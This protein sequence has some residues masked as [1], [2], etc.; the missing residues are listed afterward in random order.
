MNKDWYKTAYHR[1][2]V[3]MHITADS[4]DFLTCFD[5]DNYVEM[6]KLSRAQSAVVYAHSHVGMTYFPTKFGYMHPNLHGRDIFSEI[7][8]GCHREGINVVAYFSLIFDTWAYDNHPHWRMRHA[9]GDDWSGRDRF[10]VCCPNSSGYRAYLKKVITELC[11]GYDFEGIRFDMTFWPGFCYCDNC[12]R[13]FRE[14]YGAELPVT[15]NW[16][17]KTWVAYQRS[18]ERWLCE[19]AHEITSLIRII[20]PGITVEHQSSVF[21]QHYGFGVSAELSDENDFLQGDFYGG[22]IQG[23]CAC[24]IFYNLS[25]N[26][27]CGFETS[28][29][30]TL[31]DHT[32]VKSPELLELKAEMAIANS[33]A[34]IFI[35]AIDPIGTLDPYVYQTMSRVF[36]KTSRFEPFVGGELV[37]DVALYL[38]TESKFS[39]SENGRHVDSAAFVSEHL[40]ST[41]NAARALIRNHIPFGIITRKNLP[42]L[43]KFKMLLLCDV[44]MMSEEEISAIR[45][46]VRAGGKLYASKYSSLT[47]SDGTRL[48]NFGLAD[49][50]GADYT[51]ITE[52]NVTYLVPEDTEFFPA[53]INDT[54]PLY[55]DGSQIEITARDGAI[56]AARLC[57]PYFEPQ[58]RRPFS[59]IHSNPPGPVEESAAM[60]VNCFGAGECVYCA[61]ELENNI[62]HGNIFAGIVKSLLGE[63]IS[64]EGDAPRQVEV[65]IF[66]HGAR[67]Q[68]NFLTF[69]EELPNL[70]IPAFNVVIKTSRRSVEAVRLLP[71]GYILDFTDNGSQVTFT[72]PDFDNFCICSVEFKHHQ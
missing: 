34:F 71:D 7:C 47:L 43:K 6:L 11:D 8:D 42:E 65:T 33:C 36:D 30:V 2:V 28:S 37:Q 9:N 44:L 1:N 40:D 19:F 52:D 46:Y 35:D 18:R 57:K 16:T 31:A 14:E 17:D 38:S 4:D 68:A 3:D 59:S 50:F 15:M 53:H 48:S 5:T 63:K 24:K 72:V 66:D 56:T 23:S 61:A 49:V 21:N 51:G 58:K 54:H 27:P 62:S 13:R 55:I 70:P 26:L 20:K 29:N 39:F 60:T 69:Q 41:W 64:F 25:P 67:L 32:T 22:Y 45:E 12:R 10:G